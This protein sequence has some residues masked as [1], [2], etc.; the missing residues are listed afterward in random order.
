[1]AIRRKGGPLLFS[2][3]VIALT[4]GFALYAHGLQT[5]FGAKRYPLSARFI[6]ANG[7][8]PGAD[9]MISGVP[10]GRVDT[11]RLNPASAMAEVAFEVD[12][13]LH[14]PTDSTLSVGSATMSGDNALII[15]PGASSVLTKA[16]DVLGNTREPMS[17]EQQVSN[18]IFG[19]GGLPD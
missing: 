13:R 5:G 3:A 8:A 7:L 16:G 2:T 1:M 11:I 17:L 10:V 9:V 18:Y 6:S 4:A 14:F 15:E 19:N 12:D